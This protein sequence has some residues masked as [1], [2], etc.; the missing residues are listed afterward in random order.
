MKTIE[1]QEILAKHEIYIDYKLALYLNKLSKN[2]LKRL[3]INLCYDYFNIYQNEMLRITFMILK[4]KF[5]DIFINVDEL[6][7]GYDFKG[8]YNNLLGSKKVI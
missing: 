7:N 8:F 1:L 2:S 4:L 6:D 5:N 3:H